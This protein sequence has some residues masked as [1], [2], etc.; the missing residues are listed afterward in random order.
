[1]EHACQPTTISIAKD[2]KYHDAV[3]SVEGDEVSV[4]YWGRD[5][6]TRCKAHAESTE[7]PEQIARKLLC[8]MI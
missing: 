5:G 2:G 4:I 7:T 3:F 8:Q 1:M 6:V